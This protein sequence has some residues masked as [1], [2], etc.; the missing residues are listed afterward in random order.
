MRGYVGLWNWPKRLKLN[1]LADLFTDAKRTA[2]IKAEGCKCSA[3][4]GLSLYLIICHWALVVLPADVCP[5]ERQA[6][7]ALCDVI[8]CMRATAY[9]HVDRSTI[10][11]SVETFLHLY[12]LA[13]GMAWST[14]KFH[15]A[16]HFG[17]YVEKSSN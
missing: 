13:F 5:A 9:Q 2:H 1:K 11:K 15:W 7:V 10:L 14:P 3:S 16:L 12:D 6:F 17:D 8:D 4:E